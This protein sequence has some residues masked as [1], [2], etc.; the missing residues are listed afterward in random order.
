[1]SCCPVVEAHRGASADYPENTLCAFQ[2][3]ID[4]GARWIELDIHECASGELVVM[5]DRTVDRTT[6]GTGAIADLT[7]GQLRALDAGSW[8]GS[9]FAG[10]PVPT[11]EEVLQLLQPS[12]TCL[13]VEVKRFA[14]P[15]AAQQLADLL[16]RYA[17]KE[18]THLVSSF[19]LGA[20][21]QVREQ[22]AAIPLAFLNSKAGGVAT[23]IEN[24]FPWVHLHHGA[25]N[26]DT[27]G[28]AHAA[29]VNVMTW[30][31]DNAARFAHYTRLG[32]DKVCT[33]R[34]ATMLAARAAVL[35]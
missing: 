29:G 5:H 22:D 8:R 10:E 25:V 2:A 35:S 12:G 17:P 31:M 27:V 28:A 34:P 16:H 6:D 23:A 33:N 13:N 26:C 15:S 14:H 7:L 18:G 3:A 19:E 20:L 21:L 30:T 32:V 4:T 24:G 11:L 9:Q 1:M